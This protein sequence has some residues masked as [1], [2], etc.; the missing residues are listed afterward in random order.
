MVPLIKKQMSSERKG[1]S[2]VGAESMKNQPSVKQI[3]NILTL[4]KSYH[5][6]HLASSPSLHWAL[7]FQVQQT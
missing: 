5:G 6:P 7:L 1:K 2:Y 3:I 4:E